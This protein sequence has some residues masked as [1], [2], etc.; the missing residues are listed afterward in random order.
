[1][2]RRPQGLIG[3]TRKRT[4]KNDEADENDNVLAGL[5]AGDAGHRTSP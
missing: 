4:N 3:S 1:M 2:E 5:S